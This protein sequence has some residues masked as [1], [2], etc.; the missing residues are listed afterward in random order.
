MGPAEAEFGL[1]S[2]PSATDPSTCVVWSVIVVPGALRGK[3]QVAAVELTEAAVGQ[4]GAGARVFL[5]PQEEDGIPLRLG[6]AVVVDIQ[7]DQRHRSESLPTGWQLPHWTAVLTITV[8]GP[9]A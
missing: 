9:S 5:S 2:A 7:G 1:H 6:G 8:I 4:C 3:G